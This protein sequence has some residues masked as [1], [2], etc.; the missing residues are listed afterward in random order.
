MNTSKQL[1]RESSGN[2]TIHGSL[3]SRAERRM[4]ALAP[5]DARRKHR[6]LAVLIFGGI[7][8][9]AYPLGR[10]LAGLPRQEFEGLGVAA[11][12]LT[13]AGIFLWRVSRAL[14]QDSLQAE[15]SEDEVALPAAGTSEPAASQEEHPATQPKP[16]T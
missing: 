12:F 11:C 4:N 3:V 7:A 9:V 8:L 15:T 10:A 16:R 5:G 2:F 6:H 13:Y 1:L 14:T